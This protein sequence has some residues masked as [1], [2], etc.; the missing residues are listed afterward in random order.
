[1]IWDEEAT[2][3]PWK[4]I[5]NISLL[6]LLELVDNKYFYWS[7]IALMFWKEMG[8]DCEKNSIF[9]VMGDWNDS[10][11]TQEDFKEYLFLF[12]PHVSHGYTHHTK[13]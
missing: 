1:M 13:I 5:I 11:Q 8:R 9:Q 3:G 4:K 10:V 7:S 6:F 12:F 2:F